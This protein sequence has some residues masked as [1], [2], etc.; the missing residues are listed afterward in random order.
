MFLF[1]YLRDL[2]TREPGLLIEECVGARAALADRH[3]GRETGAFAGFALLL[4]RPDSRNAFGSFAESRGL[5]MPLFN[6]IKLLFTRK[7]INYV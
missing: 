2:Q 3:R 6:A 7:N 5:S 4:H 1:F